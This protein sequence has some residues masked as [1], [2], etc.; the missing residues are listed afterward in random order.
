MVLSLIPAST[1]TIFADDSGKRAE[2]MEETIVNIRVGTYNIQNGQNAG[3]NYDFSV[4]A[5]D[6]TDAGLDIVGLQEVDYKT[7]RNKGQDT[8]AKLSEYT[9]YQYHG[10]T[11]AI[12]LQGGGYGHGILSKYPIKSYESVMLYSTGEQ[13]AYGHAVIDVNGTEIHVFNTHTQWPSKSDRA[14]QFKELA[15]VFAKYPNSILLG[16]LNAPDRT[17]Y[18]GHFPYCNFANAADPAYTFITNEDGPIDNIIC[19][20]NTMLFLDA[21][22]VDTISNKHSDHNMLYADLAVKKNANFRQEAGGIRY[23]PN[24][25]STYATGLQ[26]LGDISMYFDPDTGLMS[27]TSCVVDGETVELVEFQCCGMTLY[28][29]PTPEEESTVGKQTVS[30]EIPIVSIIDANGYD[31]TE[32]LTDG[33]VG[34]YSD[35]RLHWYDRP[36]G[37]QWTVEN[38]TLIIGGIGKVEKDER[39]TKLD[40]D[41]TAIEVLPNTVS[42]IDANAFAG[43]SKVTR[44]NIGEGVTS[45]G[46]GALATGSDSLTVSLPSTLT[47]VGANAASSGKTVTVIL[48]NLTKSAFTTLIGSNNAGLA[49]ATVKE[50]SVTALAVTPDGTGIANQ[51]GKTLLSLILKKDGVPFAVEDGYQWRLIFSDGERTTESDDWKS[52]AMKLSHINPSSADKA[53]GLYRFEICLAEGE[54]QFIPH[55]DSVYDLIVE[56]VDR[57]GNIVYSATSARKQFFC[58]EEPIFTERTSQVVYNSPFNYVQLDFGSEQAVNKLSVTFANWSTRYYQW[59]AYATNDPTLPLYLW[60]PIGAKDGRETSDTGYTIELPKNANGEYDSYRYIRVYGSY[61]SSNWTM[62][63]AE[64]HA[65]STAVYKEVTGTITDFAGKDVTAILTDGDVDTQLPELH[66]Y[67][68]ALSKYGTYFWTVES[69]RLI[70]GGKGNVSAPYPWDEMPENVRET[71]TEVVVLPKSVTTIGADAFAAL[72]KAAT[73]TVGEG[74]TSIGK[75]ALPSVDQLTLTLPST[76]TTVASGAAGS[77]KAATVILNGKTKSAFTSLLGSGNDV[78]KNATITENTVKSLTVTPVGDGFSNATGKTLLSMTLKNADGSNFTA[79]AGSV[80]RLIFNDGQR[81]RENGGYPSEAMKLSYMTPTGSNGSYVFDICNAEGENQFIPQF[82]SSYVITVEVCDQNGVLLYSGRSAVNVF[83]C[84][85]PAIF[86]ERTA[87]PAYAG[88]YNYFQI[89]L[90]RE[91]EVAGIQLLQGTAENRYTQWQAYGS[92]DPTLPLSMWTLITEKNDTVQNSADNAAN[93]FFEAT[94]NADGGFDGYRYV[95]IY[96]SY[97]SARWSMFFGEVY[98][99]AA[100]TDDPVGDVNGDGTVNIEDVTALLQYLA[101]P[102]TT[103]IQS[104]DVNGDGVISIKDVSRLLILLESLN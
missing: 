101:E 77:S 93:R 37:P 43:L 14:V 17:E 66:W 41:V 90:G 94:P 92:N 11:K 68:E 80:W 5:K 59:E 18:A 98:V 10:Y 4:I 23:Y 32:R 91:R 3:T 20:K 71:I 55:Y 57:D 6:I 86:T 81:I 95:R 25:S 46:E 75:N 102:A 53:A 64:I 2:T 33:N 76:L 35:F 97:D 83:K 50:N 56:I 70:V 28:R 26:D 65:Y 88:H 60:T 58:K 21:K 47:S 9:G 79:P 34:T 69:G 8:M 36:V 100:N 15:E 27:T 22:M 38:K 78:L 99:Y 13:R 31:E 63:F 12:S 84:V 29:L 39:W 16:D 40:L 48:N 1:L 19:P 72:P 45:I 87:A 62:H 52:A 49:S 103:V 44:I 7:T 61:N 42:S 85:D 54:D 104:G 74:V 82:D 89:D 67:E 24:G 30:R 51:N 96:G 73:V